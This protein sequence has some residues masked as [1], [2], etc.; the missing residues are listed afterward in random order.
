MVRVQLS[1]ISLDD[2]G[3]GGVKGHM[4]GGGGVRIL[5]RSGCCDLFYSV[6]GGVLSK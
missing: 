2:G 5:T 4:A 1:L 3:G 6:L